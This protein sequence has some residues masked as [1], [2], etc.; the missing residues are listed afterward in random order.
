MYIYIC[1]QA[2]LSNLQLGILKRYKKKY[3]LPVPLGSNK[4]ELL[5]A[6]I[7]HFPTIKINET[8]DIV[9]F[10]NYMYNKTH[11]TNTN[12]SNNSVSTHNSSKSTKKSNKS[13]TNSSNKDDSNNNIKESA[14]SSKVAKA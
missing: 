2:D 6:V 12:S 9:G 7:K 3:A 4:A 5:Q 11:N 8:K 10:L 13:N 1:I 14:K